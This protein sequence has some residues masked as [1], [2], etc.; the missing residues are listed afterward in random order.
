[1]THCKNCGAA[2]AGEYCAQCGQRNKSFDR[3]IW[4][5]LGDVVRETF[6]VDGRTANT[7]K[8]LLVDP[9]GLTAEYLAGRRA[10]YTPPLRLYLAFSIAFFLLIAWFAS[11]ELLGQ[12]GVDPVFDAAIESRFLSDDLPTVMIVLLPV[13]AMLMKAMYRHR[14]YF[15]HVIFS[16]HLHCVAY[17]AFA[18]IVPLEVV[19]ESSTFLLIMQALT[20]VGF[21]IYIAFAVRRVFGM[22]WLSVILRTVIVLALYMVIVSL[23]IEYTSEQA[24]SQSVAITPN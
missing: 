1:M 2:L 12:P 7:I 19:A 14:L 15:D 13:F 16:L 9:G 20:L 21:L 3:P 24:I 8:T 23:S 6:E 17:V 18:V 10:R 5:L 4:R 22:S 11:V